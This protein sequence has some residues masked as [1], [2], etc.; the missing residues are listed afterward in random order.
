M[1]KGHIDAEPKYR[2]AAG[3]NA[4]RETSI[5]DV[6]LSMAIAT[7]QRLLRGIYIQHGAAK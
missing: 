1:F 6:S 7:C 4:L 2:I 3:E 5:R